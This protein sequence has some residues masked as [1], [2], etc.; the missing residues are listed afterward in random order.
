MTVCFARWFGRF[1]VDAR[2]EHLR[3]HPQR[4]LLHRISLTLIR[5]QSL[6]ETLPDLLGQGVLASG[7]AMPVWLAWRSAADARWHLSGTGASPTELETDRLFYQLDL[8]TRGN[9]YQL[10]SDLTLSRK[11]VQGLR[12]PDG[13]S[14]LQL[15]L[16]A[17]CPETLAMDGWR[18]MLRDLGRAVREGLDLRLTH[19]HAQTRMRQE[20][21]QTL[22][23]SLH[24]SVAQQLCYLCLQT[25]R[26]EQQAEQLSPEQLRQRLQDIRCQTRRAYRQTR[27]LISSARIRLQ[28]SLEQELHSAI[29]EFERHSSVLFELDNRLSGQHLPEPVAVELLL[30]LREAL[31]NAVRHAHASTVSIQL[32]PVNTRGFHV[33]IRDDGQGLPPQRN[34]DS[35][36]LGIMKERATRIGAH[37]RLESRPGQ[38]TSIEVIAE[39]SC[40]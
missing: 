31:S 9:R 34:A 23:A 16:L 18:Q 29:A 32:L 24:D 11:T 5:C 26:L 14:G 3:Y 6:E 12:V 4:E 27:E 40:S 21:Q 25:G 33:R 38:G 7:L 10:Q 39:D 30:I 20:M 37:F 13:E 36:G 22:A 28:H 35:F 8:A 2:A 1:Q 15:W 19:E 17:P